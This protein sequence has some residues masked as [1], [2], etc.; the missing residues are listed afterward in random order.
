MHALTQSSWSCGLKASTTFRALSNQNHACL[1]SKPRNNLCCAHEG[2]PLAQHP[3][4]AS[5][6]NIARMLDQPI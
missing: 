6:A 1:Q 4:A 2:R 5:E 3:G